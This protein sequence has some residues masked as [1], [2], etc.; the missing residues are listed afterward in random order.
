M[1]YPVGS[2]LG[3][4]NAVAAARIGESGAVW[5]A[6]SGRIIGEDSSNPLRVTSGRPDA[7]LVC[8]AKTA[9]WDLSPEPVVAGGLVCLEDGERMSVN[10][11][12]TQPTVMTTSYRWPSMWSVGGFPYEKPRTRTYSEHEPLRLIWLNRDEIC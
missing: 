1:T 10:P 7:C 3:L 8:A 4:I 11:S 2:K 5:G 6:G 12:R 9:T